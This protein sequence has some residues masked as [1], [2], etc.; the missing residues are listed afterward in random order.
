MTKARE[1][2]EWDRARCIQSFGATF[3]L[4]NWT[5]ASLDEWRHSGCCGQGCLLNSKVG[6]CPAPGRCVSNQGCEI[7]GGSAE[8]KGLKCNAFEMKW[9]GAEEWNMTCW[10]LRPGVLQV[11]GH[12][13]MLSSVCVC[14]C[15]WRR[16][17]LSIVRVQVECVMWCRLPLLLWLPLLPSC[18]GLMEIKGH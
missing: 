10:L 1:V 8:W 15:V 17:N 11:T 7:A 4:H 9:K 13:S 16:E 18:S 12:D 6:I 2:K 14:V 5:A 3:I